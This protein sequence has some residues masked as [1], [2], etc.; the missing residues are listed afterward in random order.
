MTA[1][2]GECLGVFVPVT[3]TPAVTVTPVSI[4]GI[5]RKSKEL[6]TFIPTTFTI[7]VCHDTK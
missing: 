3:V 2:F 7:E 1:Y 5:E 6:G 4:G